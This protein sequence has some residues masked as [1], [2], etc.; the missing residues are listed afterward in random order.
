MAIAETALDVLGLDDAKRQLW[1][2]DPAEDAKVQFCLKS[3]VDWVSRITGRPLIKQS[4]AAY[5]DAPADSADPLS[6]ET[7]DFASLDSIAY[8]EPSQS[9]RDAATGTVAIAELGRIETQGRCVSVWPPQAG[10]PAVLSGSSIVFSYSIGYDYQDSDA[11]P[12]A[13]AVVARALYESA[14]EPPAAAI[15][16]MVKPYIS[17]AS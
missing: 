9:L 14:H 15:R 13:V 2:D 11:M 3:A 7:V 6:F 1:I 4:R 8:H 17:D 12:Q 16:M 10:W 5:F